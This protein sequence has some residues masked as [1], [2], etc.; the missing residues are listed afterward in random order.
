MLSPFRLRLKS[1]VLS[2]FA[3]FDF[4]LL[5]AND[6]NH[7]RRLM[8]F[9]ILRQELGQRLSTKEVGEFLGIDDDTVRKH[10]KKLG[11]IRPTGPKGRILFFEQNVVDAL[12]R[13]YALE[14]Q[15]GWANSLE[16]KDPEARGDTYSHLQ[17]KSGSSGMGDRAKKG[18]LVED[19][20]SL[21]PG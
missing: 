20:H 12:R 16:G 18:R 6:T 3:I 8:T 4:A 7:E 2:R 5:L 10:Y 14:D 9:D 13:N 17:H 1:L 11:G 15:E 19:K 21:F